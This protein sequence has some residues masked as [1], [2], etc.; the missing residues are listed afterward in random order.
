M[1]A[2][3][4]YTPVMVVILSATS[5][6]YSTSG[7]AARSAELAIRNDLPRPLAGVV[8]VDA[9]HLNGSRTASVLSLPFDSLSPSSLQRFD[10]TAAAQ[11]CPPTSCVLAST[12]ID[13]S[14]NAVATNVQLQV[15]A[16]Q[17]KN[18]GLEVSIVRI[19]TGA[20][21]FYECAAE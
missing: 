13:T 17:Q 7:P 3:H 5:V 19:T 16:P 4:L 21:L 15:T 12:V 1:L 2:Q 14:Q 6:S 9:V 10:A 11:A 8:R 20:I 18:L